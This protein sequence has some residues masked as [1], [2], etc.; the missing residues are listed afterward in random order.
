MQF[1]CNFQTNDVRYVRFTS[2]AS[3]IINKTKNVLGFFTS[4]SNELFAIGREMFRQSAEYL[5]S[6]C[7]VWSLWLFTTIDQ[8]AFE[9]TFLSYS[10]AVGNSL[11][12]SFF[13]HISYAFHVFTF[14]SDNYKRLLVSIK[15]NALPC[16]C[17]IFALFDCK[18]GQM[19]ATII[20]IVFFYVFLLF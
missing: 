3:L 1:E 4:P 11:L 7:F 6:S 12:S 10:P 14:H 2:S 16:F 13:R 9:F 17:H 5:L 20:M 18:T 8:M 19:F 15:Q